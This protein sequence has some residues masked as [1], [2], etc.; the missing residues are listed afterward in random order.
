MSGRDTKSAQGC[1]AYPETEWNP[2][3]HQHSAAFRTSLVERQ[4][5]LQREVTAGKI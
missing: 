4:L 5:Q 2:S 1:V 3:T